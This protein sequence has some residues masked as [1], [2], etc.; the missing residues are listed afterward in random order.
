MLEGRFARTLHRVRVSGGP[1]LLN[2]S[3][4]ISDSTPASRIKEAENLHGASK[5]FLT[6]VAATTKRTVNPQPNANF[7][8][9]LRYGFAIGLKRVRATAS[10]F[11]AVGLGKRSPLECR[12]FAHCSSLPTRIIKHS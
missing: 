8:A 4:A 7:T 5:S 10:D 12:Q 2:A 11:A 6:P 1:K 9:T 3:M